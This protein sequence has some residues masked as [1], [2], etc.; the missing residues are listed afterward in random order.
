LPEVAGQAAELVDP[1][2]VDSIVT[3]VRRLL[4]DSVLRTRLQSLGTSQSRKFSWEQA[5][6][7]TWRVLEAA[8][9]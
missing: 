3:G 5:A 8:G 2:D 6:D 9:G 1:L 4:D 7:A